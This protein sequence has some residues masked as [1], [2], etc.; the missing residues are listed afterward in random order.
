MLGQ[1]AWLSAQEDANR[2]ATPFG[3][4]RVV[5]VGAAALV[6][7]VMYKASRTVD[8][9]YRAPDSYLIMPAL[10]ALVALRVQ[11]SGWV[12]GWW[13]WGAV[14]HI[15]SLAPGNTHVSTLWELTY[16]AA[17][18]SAWW[19]P[20]VWVVL[21]LLGGNALL[22]MLSLNAFGL[23]QYLSGSV[24]YVGGALLLPL[25]P[26]SLVGGLRGK[27]VWQ[28]VAWSILAGVALYGALASGARAVYLP[29]ALVVIVAGIRVA[30]ERV[31][32]R[33]LAITVLGVSVVVVGL[34]SAQPWHPVMTALGAK[35]SLGTQVESSG[36][37]GA[38]SQRLRFWDQALDIA[39][40]NPLGAGNGSFEAVIHS[41]QKYPMAW[42]NSP[43]NYYVETLANGGWP[44]SRW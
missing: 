38:F 10:V 5:A 21:G 14:T 36:E 4:P 2:R 13:L 31:P 22:D 16:L 25:V 40:A 35:A 41:Y 12:W 6:A 17:F 1:R 9:S 32:L 42:S 44:Q 24:H 26:L 29:L 18:A 27:R 34:E 28:V 37:R 15:W 23:E 3:W 19:R 33:N 20:V 39:L 11:V 8:I 43:H 30:M 7:L